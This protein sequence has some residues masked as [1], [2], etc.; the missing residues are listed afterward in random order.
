MA[1]LAPDGNGT[2]PIVFFDGACPLCNRSVAFLARRDRSGRLFFAHL[3][4]EIAARHLDPALRSVA[5][6]ATVV[7]LEP[8]ARGRVS[9]RSAAVLRDR[10]ERS[11]TLYGV[12]EFAGEAARRL[13]EVVRT[14]DVEAEAR[15]LNAEADRRHRV[16]AGQGEVVVHADPAGEHVVEEELLAAD[17][18]D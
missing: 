11:G 6:D 9:V 18:D 3:Q 5:Q 16:G 1:A 4:G 2:A 12:A 13:L 15:E 10:T 7:L 14:G 8:G 17:A